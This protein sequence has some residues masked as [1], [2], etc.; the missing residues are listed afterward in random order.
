MKAYIIEE[1]QKIVELRRCIILTFRFSSVTEQV[2]WYI[3]QNLVHSLHT[4]ARL[5]HRGC[6]RRWDYSSRQM[7]YPLV[8]PK[9]LEFGSAFHKAMEVFY[10][11]MTW[12]QWEVAAALAK[13]AFKEACMEQYRRYKKLNQGNIDPTMKAE[14]EDRVKMGLGMLDYYTKYEAPR[15]DV[16]FKPVKVE[17]EFEVPITGPEGEHLWCKCD[18]CWRRYT[19]YLWSQ[20]GLASEPFNTTKWDAE[21]AEWEGLP[22]TYGGR[23]DMLAQDD[24]G[25]YWVFDWKTAARLAGKDAGTDDDFMYLDDQITSYCWALWVIGFPIAGFVYAEIKKAVPEE[26]EPLQRQRLGRWYSVA[27][28]ISTTYEMYYD[29]VS[30]NDSAALAAGLYDDFLAYL[31]SDEGPKYHIRHEIERT[32]TELRNAGINIWHEACEMVDP[33]HR[34]FP[35]PGR[36]SCGNCAYKEPCVMQNRGEDYQ[37]TLDT[38]FEKRTKHYWEDRAPS[39]DSRGGA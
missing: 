7:Y 9:P 15:H 23:I 33:N 37:Y 35:S 17:I 2:N 34:I 25:R 3:E 32:E 31:K 1:D 5:S 12:G 22:V 21:R 38:M 20:Q 8:T 18:Q 10:D 24:L 16:N 11:P 4:S 29:T 14:Y 27:R 13:V 19:R 30:E 39:T 36:F 28:N 6:R 26:P